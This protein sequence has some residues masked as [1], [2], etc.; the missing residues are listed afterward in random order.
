MKIHTVP[1]G[2]SRQ[3][4]NKYLQRAW[5]MLPG[6]VIRD[7]MK[8]K[9][10]RVN[11]VKCGADATVSAG[12]EL[13]IYILDQYFE[14][15][16]D[17]IYEDSELLAVSKPAGLPVDADQKHVGADTLKSRVQAKYPGAQ[18]C[19]RLDTGTSG[20]VL[21][22]KTQQAHEQL[23][24]AFASHELRKKYI[25]VVAGRMP[26]ENQTLKAWLKKDAGAAKV[27]V[28]DH[29]A[30]GAQEIRTQYRLLEVFQAGGATLSRLEVTLITGRTHQIRAHMA[31][32]DHPLVGD[33]KYGDRNLNRKFTGGICLHAAE[34]TLLGDGVPD[35]WVGMTF[36]SPVPQWNFSKR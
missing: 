13:K 19:H 27:R 20:V 28:L 36:K 11:G 25:C 16:L 4:L 21:C 15:P 12:D 22:A 26:Y 29:P 2:V 1:E 5:P 3:Q 7:A 6:W 8:T 33:D 23:L 18:L 14:A 30:A 35:K 32:V 31:H 24:R 17:V 9:S 10:V 34:L